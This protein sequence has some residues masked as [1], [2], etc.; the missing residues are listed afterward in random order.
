MPR[1]RGENKQTLNK[2]ILI[3]NFK[4]KKTIDLSN[5]N[6]DNRP[7]STTLLDVINSCAMYILIYF[8]V[9]EQ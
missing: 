2:K 7:V 9:N 8:I 5:N 6:N 4:W 1:G 3:F